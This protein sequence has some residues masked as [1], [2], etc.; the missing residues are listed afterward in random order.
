MNIASQKKIVLLGMM[1]KMPVAGNIWLVVQYL[2]GFQRLGYDV[3]YVEAH[4]CTPRELMQEETDDGWA[5][6]AQF[7]DRVMRRFDMGDH[8]A[9]HARHSD[10]RVYG[11]SDCQL[12]DL[13]RSAA[14]IINLHGGTEPLP[15]HAAT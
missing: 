9:Y 13:Y 3:Y 8:W 11:M 10:D 14:L 5:A 15:E 1:S 12:N 6:A 7:I 2:I 4:G